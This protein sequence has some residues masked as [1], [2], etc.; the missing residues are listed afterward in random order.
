MMVNTADG[1]FFKALI[2]HLLKHRIYYLVNSVLAT[3]FA[4]VVTVSLDNIYVSK[5]VIYSK[6]SA[7]SSLES[8]AQEL[9]SIGSALGFAAGGAKSLSD[10]R[11]ILASLESRDFF[12]EHL[13]EPLTPLLY[14]VDG[15]EESKGATIYNLG[16]WNEKTKR[17]AVDEDGKSLQPSPYQAHKRFL[18]VL[19]VLVDGPFLELSVESKDPAVAARILA[20]ILEKLDEDISRDRRAETQ[21]QIAFLSESINSVDVVEVR[22]ALAELLQ[23]QIRT[24]ALMGTS[25]SLF[26][27]LDP[28]TTD[29]IP[30]YPNKV[31]FFIVII[32]LVAIVSFFAKI[33]W[34]SLRS[35]LKTA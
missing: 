20:T 9:G 13:W 33:G 10:D 34:S 29:P 21:R 17:W 31:L 6:S 32:L 15:F 2:L 7:G 14:A 24:M 19:N 30:V 5:A 26:V 8:M 12:T 18:S 25:E 3:M 28:P 27:I 1:Y 16:L 4:F 22:Q 35:T 11:L 23:E